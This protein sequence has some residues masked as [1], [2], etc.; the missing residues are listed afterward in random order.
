MILYLVYI[1]VFHYISF[2]YGVTV[3]SLHYVCYI[4]FA[5]V[6]RYVYAVLYLVYNFYSVILSV[7]LY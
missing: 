3:T 6:F 2:N 1:T 7:I 5:L 4:W